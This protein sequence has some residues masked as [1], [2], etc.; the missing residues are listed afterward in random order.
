MA[1]AGCCR[2]RACFSFFHI[3][4]VAPVLEC[5]PC[6]EAEQPPFLLQFSVRDAKFSQSLGNCIWC[7]VKEEGGKD[8]SLLTQVS[9]LFLFFDL[10]Y[11]QGMCYYRGMLS[12]A[13]SGSCVCLCVCIYFLCV[14]VTPYSRWEPRCISLGWDAPLSDA[15]ACGWDIGKRGTPTKGEGKSRRMSDMT[16]AEQSPA[17]CQEPLPQLPAPQTHLRLEASATTALLW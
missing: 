15:C 12:H 1:P 10:N 14:C 2:K 5:F 9:P 13:C 16:G 4:C 8:L 3:E 7:V 6:L 17:R 11:N